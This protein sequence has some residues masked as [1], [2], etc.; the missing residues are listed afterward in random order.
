MSDTDED[1]DRVDMSA[2]QRA[3]DVEIARRSSLT[4]AAELEKRLQQ[5]AAQL[6]ISATRDRA[7]A[8]TRRHWGSGNFVVKPVKES[9]EVAQRR[10]E[11]QS[12]LEGLAHG[13]EGAEESLQEALQHL[14][15][16]RAQ[17]A[18]LDHANRRRDEILRR[19]E[20][21]EREQHRRDVTD[22]AVA[23]FAELDG[24]E[25]AVQAARDA[26]DLDCGGGET[27]LRAEIESHEE[28]IEQLRGVVRE[29]Q[30][31]LANARAQLH[32]LDD[33]DV[34]AAQALSERN[35]SRRDVH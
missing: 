11:L 13:V 21:L 32:R 7:V 12:E 34:E 4:R 31:Q 6:V 2:S 9:A 14:D 22:E 25:A 30:R 16:I 29:D 33:A 28:L 15:R 3:L 35:R 23:L 26:L 24:A 10:A 17:L 8:A 1:D 20:A 18:P 5:A 19:Q 27:G